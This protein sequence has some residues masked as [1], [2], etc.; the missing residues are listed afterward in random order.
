[1]AL[2]YFKL[3]VIAAGID[4]RIRMAAADSAANPEDDSSRVGATVAPLIATGL[5]ALS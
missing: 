4:F 5:A 3:A 1:M 2:G